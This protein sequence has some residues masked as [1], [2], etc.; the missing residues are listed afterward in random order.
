MPDPFDDARRALDEVRA[1]DLWE[2]AERR[3]AADTVVPLAATARHPR[4]PGRWL[5]VA[6]AVALAAATVA[7]VADDDDQSVDTTP[8]ATTS[9][10]EDGMADDGLTIVGPDGCRIGIGGE[11]VVVD[12]GSAEPYRFPA[13]GSDDQLVFH[14][15]LGASQLAEV[16]V[17]GV[18]VID[19]MGERV[20]DVELRRGTAQ[21]WFGL[22]FVQ[23]RWFTASQEPCDSFTVTVSGGSED[24]NRHAAVDLAERILL[25]DE[26]ETEEPGA[27]PPS[28]GTTTTTDG[29]VITTTTIGETT[30]SI[31]LEGVQGSVTAGPT[32]PV[33]APDDPCP[34]EPLAIHIV[35]LDADGDIAAETD[36]TADG[37][38]AMALP[39]GSYTLQAGTPG[40]LPSCPDTPVDVPVGG[41]VVADISC[42]TGIR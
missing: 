37:R 20:E 14:V 26:L 16:H 19:L 32:C 23:V 10:T 11:P 18:V 42:D 13:V 7:A 41:T 22:D 27:G 38:Y 39:S 17:P 5:A 15:P 6:A 2:E 30:T 3:A 25:P 31:G 35:A 33:E 29:V 12:L 8:Q 34:P 36:S 24:A 21:V 28:D 40:G 9:T 1:P 4:H